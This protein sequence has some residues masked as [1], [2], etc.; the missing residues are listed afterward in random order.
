[1]WL[2]PI[3]P[4]LSRVSAFVYYRVRYAGEPVP[5]S[6][7]VLLVAN[8]QNS[9]FD[10]ILVVA[11][12]GRPVRFLAKAP[13]FTD[14][15]IG[16]AIRAA[17]AIPVYRRVDDP[18]EMGRNVD[19]FR[20]VYDELG[21]GAAVGIFPE[22]ISHSEPSLV[23]LKTGA[24]RI[25]LGTFERTGRT[26]PI[27]PVGLVF[28]HKERFRS[29]VIVF[30]GRPVQWDDIVDPAHRT[31]SDAA[32]AREAELRVDRGDSAAVREL[33]D[34]ITD[35]LRQVTLNLEQW[36]DRPLVECAVRIWEAERREPPD[37]GERV[38]RLELTTRLLANARRD[39]NALALELAEDVRSYCRRL[40]RLRLRPTDLSADVRLSR[41][42]SWAA[43]RIHLLLPLGAFIALLG[44]VLFWIP[45]RVTGAIVGRLRLWEDVRS[46][47]KLL[48][49]IVV[50]L[51]WV[52]GLTVAASLLFDW[53]AAAGVFVGAPILGM[54]GLII[55]ERWRKAWSDARRFFLIRSRRELVA[56]LR[57]RQRDLARRIE[58]LLTVSLQR[59]A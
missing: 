13:L 47:W 8:H 48:V 2:L 34:R 43:R 42:V 36:E 6:G 50:Y 10:P 17:G 53:R 30:A 18:T 59:G 27:I 31:W 57:E 52:V 16:W 46:T 25:A 9:L 1:M 7:S 55:R 39:G 35:A 33:T 56:G 45:Y 5:A 51:V 15:L 32:V 28:R 41:G 3:F 12:A 22:G 24:A 11:A 26:F 49:G 4:R 14:R 21:S 38:S 40:S 23:P 37:A 54:I 29:D 20:A 44:A 19:T 58:D